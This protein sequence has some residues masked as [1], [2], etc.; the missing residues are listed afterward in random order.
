MITFLALFGA[1]TL[2]FLVLRALR[3][4]AVHGSTAEG[5]LAGLA[6]GVLVLV[7]PLLLIP[8]AALV[9]ISAV[10]TA[11][12]RPGEPGAA[13]AA[14]SLLM[15]PAAAATASSAFLIWRLG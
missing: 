11:R 6:F 3:R 9:A 8:V 12:H 14:A 5:L 2:L 1:G 7:K 4:F 13:V 15:F 10:I